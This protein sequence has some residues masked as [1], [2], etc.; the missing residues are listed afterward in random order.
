M[1]ITERTWYA[2]FNEFKDTF[3]NVDLR[4]VVSRFDEDSDKPIKKITDDLDTYNWISTKYINGC[5]NVSVVA[6]ATK[7][8]SSKATITI[9]IAGFINFIPFEDTVHA[10][11]DDFDA[12]ADM[13]YT[14]MERVYKS[15]VYPFVKSCKAFFKAGE[16]YG[17]VVILKSIVAP[18]FDFLDD[19]CTAA[20][21]QTDIIL[22][23]KSVL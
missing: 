2:I 4:D 10:E 15:E 12:Y 11:L 8:S 1:Y 18:K 7:S 17:D 14:D 16:Q 20:L 5:P 21:Y 19:S 13:C 6:D 3:L 9:S 23:V 22:E